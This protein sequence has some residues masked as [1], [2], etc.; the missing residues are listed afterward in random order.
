MIPP[1]AIGRGKSYLHKEVIGDCTLYLGDC[2][3]VLSDIGTVDHILTDPP[4]G[5]TTHKGARSLH[6]DGTLDV[7]FIDFASISEVDLIAVVVEFLSI[8]KRWL[9]FTCEW[10]FAAGL[11]N[12]F[13]DEFIRL[14]VWLK[15]NGAPQYTGDRPSTGWEA[16]VIMHNKG[17]KKW[18][19]GGHHATW[20][21]NIVTPGTN[22]HP[23][24]KP[25]PLVSDWIRKFTDPGDIILDPYMGSGTTLYCAMKLGRR[26]IGIEVDKKHFDNACQRIADAHANSDMFIVPAKPM[27]Q[28]TLTDV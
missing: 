10:R 25:I 8:T 20:I 17:R 16:V 6:R 21:E 5:E 2:K 9:I 24:Q 23:T 19:G 7:G 26:A 15:P 27:K 18:N 1:L 3:E 4:Y 14:G 12:A 22:I 13:P 11:E 28:I